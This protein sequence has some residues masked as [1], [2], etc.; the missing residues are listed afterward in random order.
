MLGNARDSEAGYTRHG[1]GES[2]RIRGKV[3]AAIECGFAGVHD[4][5]RSVWTR[6]EQ[7]I[8]NCPASGGMAG[9]A[10]TTHYG[11]SE[12]GQNNASAIVLRLGGWLRVHA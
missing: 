7:C 9:C 5:L 8:R 12:P 1:A 3:I 11:W 10:C 2:M 4:T 6:A